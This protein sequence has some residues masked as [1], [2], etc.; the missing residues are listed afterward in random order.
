[1]VSFEFDS[2]GPSRI[3]CWIPTVT[4]SG[5]TT[6][7]QPDSETTGAHRPHS[8]SCVM[9]DQPM[10]PVAVSNEWH[11]CMCVLCVC[12]E[13]NLTLKSRNGTR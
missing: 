13:W 4:P 6:V 1:M 12:Q 9:F 8:S 10:S 5:I 3:E 11:V 2:G 7:W